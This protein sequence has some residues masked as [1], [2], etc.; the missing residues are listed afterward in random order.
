MRSYKLQLEILVIIIQFAVFANLNLVVVDIN[1][2]NSPCITLGPY[3]LSFLII[4]LC[5]FLNFA[6]TIVCPL[7]FLLGKGNILPPVIALLDYRNFLVDDKYF[8]IF[9]N[10]LKDLEKKESHFG[11]IGNHAT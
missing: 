3:Y 9:Y 1:H 6:V 10:F 5:D 2:F 7:V 8:L 11:L 4:L